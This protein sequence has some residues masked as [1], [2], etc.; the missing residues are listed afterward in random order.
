[1]EWPVVAA[2]A[3]VA[4][5]G[6]TFLAFWM[7]LGDRITRADGRSKGA[8]DAAVEAKREMGEVRQQIAT[9]NA[10]FALYREQIAREYIHREAMREIEDRLTAAI[11]RVGARLDRF[12]DSRPNGA[13]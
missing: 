9:I 3:A 6:A 4:G 5:G 1:M 2:L 11:D 13:R 12:L 7:G 10:Q 8:W